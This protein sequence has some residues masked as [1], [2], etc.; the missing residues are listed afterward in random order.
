MLFVPSRRK[1]RAGS[2]GTLKTQ[3]Y[4]TKGARHERK[5]NSRLEWR[6]RGGRRQ[7]A[8][9]RCPETDQAACRVSRSALLSPRGQ[10]VSGLRVSEMRQ[11]GDFDPPWVPPSREGVRESRK[12]AVRITPTLKVIGALV[13]ISS[14]LLFASCLTSLSRYLMIEVLHE[15]ISPIP[16]WTKLLISSDGIL[17]QVCVAAS[18]VAM[19]A[20]L[21]LGE[22][23][24]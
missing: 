15:E 4:A 12:R 14:F 10:G 23:G 5:P 17:T 18:F 6:I 20:V 11:P 2:Q 9:P 1:I 3:L 8:R 16:Y 7:L 24:E 19:F 13:L 22:Q 21:L